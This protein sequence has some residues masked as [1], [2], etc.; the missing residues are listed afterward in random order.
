MGIH[1][2]DSFHEGG[3]RY[4]GDFIYE[5]AEESVFP[6]LWRSLWGRGG[7]CWCWCGLVMWD[8][9]VGFRGF[10]VGIP[11]Y[12]KF[13]IAI[14]VHS[15]RRLPGS[16]SCGLLSVWALVWVVGV[17]CWCGLSVWVVGVGF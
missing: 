12:V 13:Y 16:C 4:I 2:G 9:G 6:S 3:S 15:Y 1:K 11:T 10:G 14:N 8:A 7:I 5:T 17:G